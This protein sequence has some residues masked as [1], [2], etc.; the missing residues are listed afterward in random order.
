MT[1]DVT[2]TGKGLM[3][4]EMIARLWEGSTSG[5]TAAT[6]LNSMVTYTE[7]TSADGL[8]DFHRGMIYKSKFA[9]PGVTPIGLEILQ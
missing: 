9:P 3:Q 2:A 1:Y 7:K 6:P 4:A 8:F 5:T